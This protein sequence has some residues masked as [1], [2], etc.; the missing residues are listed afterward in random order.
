MMLAMKTKNGTAISACLSITLV[1]A[2]VTR[3][4]PL[5][6]NAKYAVVTEI[7][8]VEAPNGTPMAMSVK[9]AATMARVMSSIPTYSTPISVGSL[10]FAVGVR[11][12]ASSC[13]K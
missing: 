13:R 12:F 5:E 6:P 3:M 1:T 11:R 7:N 4:K 8:S 10:S 9:S 2:E